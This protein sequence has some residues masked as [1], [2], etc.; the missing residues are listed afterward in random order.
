MCKTRCVFLRSGEVSD[1]NVRVNFENSDS[2]YIEASITAS[3]FS[4]R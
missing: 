1:A 4:K 3:E 2:L